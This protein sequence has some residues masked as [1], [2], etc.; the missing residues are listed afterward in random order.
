MLQGNKSGNKYN[1]PIKNG[2]FAKLRPCRQSLENRY[3]YFPGEYFLIILTGYNTK[4]FTWSSTQQLNLLPRV[5]TFHFLRPSV[6]V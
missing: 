4:V 6:D 2:K 3:L 1:Y 5:N